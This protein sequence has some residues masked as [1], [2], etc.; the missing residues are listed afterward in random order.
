M[1]QRKQFLE[2]LKLIMEQ[3]EDEFVRG[4]VKF[5]APHFRVTEQVW[6]SDHTG[7]IDIVLK[8]DFQTYFGV[9][10]KRHDSK[11][12]EEMGEYIKQAIRYSKCKFEVE[13]KIFKRIPILICPPLSYE[14]FLLNEREIILKDHATFGHK[15]KWHQDRHEEHNEHHS[16]NGFLG[17]FGIGELRK[18]HNRYDKWCYIS[19]ANKPVWSSEK[20]LEWTGRARP[21]PLGHIKGVD[22]RWYEAW[23]KKIASL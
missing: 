16:F 21:T 5:F 19:Y 1:Y 6:N 15:T 2:K 3:T 18:S 4:V 14:Y 11:R 10:C 13:P 7:R 22:Q 20:A 8:Y 23:M 17:A 12:G 9:E